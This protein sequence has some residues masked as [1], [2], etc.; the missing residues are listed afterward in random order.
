MLKQTLQQKLLQKLSPQQI[1]LMKLLQIPTMELEQRIKEELEENPALEEGREEDEFESNADDFEEDTRTESEKEIDVSDYMDDDEVP[2]QPATSNYNP[3]NEDRQTPIKQGKS[4]QDNVLSQLYFQNIEEELLFF[5]E[6]MV[7]YLDD[8]GYVQRDLE[9]IVDDLAFTQGVYTD[10]ATLE[11]AL[12]HVQ[13]LEPYGIGARN[14]RE[15]LLIQLDN[16]PKDG[17][18]YL[19]AYIIIRDHFELFT[20][21]HY[22]KIKERLEIGDDELKQALNIILKLNPKPGNSMS[23]SA[24]S[25]HVVIPDFEIVNRDG[26][27]VLSLTQGNIPELKVNGQYKEMLQTYSETG[28]NKEAATFVK[29]KLDGAKWFIEAIRQRNRTLML[30]MNAIVDRQREFFLSGDRADIRPMILKD[31]AEKVEMDISTISRV[32]NSKY[33]RTEFGVFLLKSF[34]SESMTNASGEEVSTIEIKTILKDV[35]ANEDKRKP[36]TDEKLKTMLDE[37]GYPIA[38]RTVAKYREQLGLP[39]ARLRKEVL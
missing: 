7:G 15:C 21:K 36:L 28:S 17:D 2:Y 9:A 32:A 39:V 5:A 23:E 22:K 10:V 35:I 12:S 38:R 26:E 1:Q 37:K 19:N 24:H 31:I 4:F 34:F 11:K 16:N 14:L 33:V 6:T 18:D 8:N 20:K 25:T 13:K 27:L 29:Q 3:D 30:T